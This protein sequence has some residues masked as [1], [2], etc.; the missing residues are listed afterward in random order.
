VLALRYYLDLPEDEIAAMLG[1]AR[2]TVSSTVARAL[3]V[4]VQQFAEAGQ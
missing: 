1:I 2:G 4:L 3:A